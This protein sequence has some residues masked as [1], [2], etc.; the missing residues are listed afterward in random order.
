MFSVI[1]QCGCDCMFMCMCMLLVDQRVP[2]QRNNAAPNSVKW[3][4]CRVPA[5][6]AAVKCFPEQYGH[7]A[8]ETNTL[9]AT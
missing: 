6:D 2:L 4:I 9:H 8:S 3:A 5:N 1:S 7:Y